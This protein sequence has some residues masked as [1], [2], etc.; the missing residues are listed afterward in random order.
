[1]LVQHHLEFPEQI[2]F[3]KLFGSQVEARV[4]LFRFV[5]KRHEIMVWPFREDR[6][7]RF[8]RLEIISNIGKITVE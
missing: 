7:G 3:F 1:M 4:T 8:V 2:V 5:T 6:R